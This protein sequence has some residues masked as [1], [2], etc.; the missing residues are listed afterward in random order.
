MHL[1]AAKFSWLKLRVCAI[2]FSLVCNVSDGIWD[3]FEYDDAVSYVQKRK[4]KGKSAQQA[5][6]ALVHE[7]LDR[8]STDNCSAI[9]MFFLQLLFFPAKCATI[10]QLYF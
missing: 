3:K 8:G 9:S 2:D 6:D 1:F 10:L 7:A 4:K 5:A